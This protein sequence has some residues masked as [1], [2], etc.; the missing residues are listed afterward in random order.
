[1]SPT[2]FGTV[3]MDMGRRLITRGIDV[4][5][6]S[7][8]ETSGPLPEPFN[9]RTL[10]IASLITVVN[11]MTGEGGVSGARPIAS[12]F[13][14]A[15]KSKLVSGEPWGDWHPQA[16]ILL[17]DIQNVRYQIATNADLTSVRGFHYCPVEGVDLPRTLKD[18]L[19]RVM[20]PVAMSSF[21]A[22]EIEK[23]MGVRPPV[24]YHGIDT[25]VFHPV[26]PSSPVVFKALEKG[27][28]DL[29]LTTKYDCKAFWAAWFGVKVPRTWMLRTDRHMPR[30]RYNSML[31]ALVPVLAANP[32]A[33]VIVHCQSTDQGGSLPDTISKLPG[34]VE[35]KGTREPHTDISPP[36]GFALFGRDYP[37]IMLTNLSG[38]KREQLVSLYNA[39]DLYL[40][41]S[42]E[43][44]GLTI[45]EALACG[46]PA[47]GLDYSAVPEVIGPAGVVVRPAYLFDNEYDH[48]WAA[49]DEQRFA[50]AVHTLLNDSAQ[51]ETLGRKGPRHIRANFSWDVAA[52][53][54]ADLLHASAL[55]V[56]A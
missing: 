16:T 48:F 38:L 34:V 54:F 23:V 35:V 50:E 1:M 4:R 44:F 7:Q 53:Q 22:D 56:A 40:S 39:S 11:E 33:M 36:Q 17:G 47:I 3:T 9:S 27:R 37:Q 10:S 14:D 32:D 29:R 26:K 19:W 42:A 8:N 2:G 55:E 45:A 30:K 18:D 20:T 5:F 25:A 51:R 31:R 13:R 15:S 46:V 41:T 49:V 21:G 6:I 43:G 24:V 12:L 52:D 28:A